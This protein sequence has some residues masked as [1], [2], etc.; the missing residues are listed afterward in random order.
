RRV[1]PRAIDW[2]YRASEHAFDP[3]EDT[4]LGAVRSIID[5]VDLTASEVHTDGAVDRVV[6]A[7]DEADIPA[8]SRIG[9]LADS[10]GALE[11]GSVRLEAD[12]RGLFHDVTVGGTVATG[13]ESTLEFTM[14]WTYG[15]FDDIDVQPPDWLSEV[16]DRE[17]PEV[18]LR[19]EEVEGRH[20]AVHI[21][22]LEH[23]VQVLVVVDG[24]G[25][26]DVAD[27]PGVITVPAETYTDAS[28]SVRD[29]L[30]FVAD[31]LRG[32]QRV[33]THVPTPVDR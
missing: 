11:R 24:E 31:R 5:S 8:K 10:M 21:D 25:V 13:E 33:D 28:G 4:R 19:I 15:S 23:A 30:V 20:V 1:E 14:R 17:R 3:I 26:V 27:A 9:E 22:R 29:V 7:A 16:P 12:D 32:P 18:D 6:Y 2:E